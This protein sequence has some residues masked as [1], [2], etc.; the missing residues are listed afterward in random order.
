MNALFKGR[1]RDQRLRGR[2]CVVTGASSGIGRRTALDLA[3]AGGRVCAAARRTELLAELVAEM[4]G[5][6]AGHSYHRTDVAVRSDVLGLAAHVER[7]YG[8]CDVLVNNAGFGGGGAFRGPES[9]PGIEQM[10]ATN[11]LGAVYCTGEL[12]DLLRAS[13]PAHVVNVASIAGRLAFGGASAYCAS[14]FAL[15][16][17]S[18]ALHAE[19]KPVGIH[20]SLVEP[21][22][23][24]TQGFP[25]ERLAAV[26]L[27]RLALTSEEVVSKAIGGAIQNG[28]V[29]RVVPRWYYL[30]QFP[31]LAIPPVFRYVGD[32]VV[33]RR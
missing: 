22:P 6:A 8:R 12:L 28:K 13:A 3:L 17:W 26:P 25:M 14:K 7:T 1:D 2:V 29:Q 11:F 33:A 31:R 21:G 30:L 10:V 19:L 23:L 20:V 4:G 32:K 27:L 15:V 16:G 18:E 5:E 9:I 24:P